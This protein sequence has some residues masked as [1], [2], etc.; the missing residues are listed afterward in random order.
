MK[1]TFCLTMFIILLSLS[2]SPAQDFADKPPL[3]KPGDSWYYR[4]GKLNDVSFFEHLEVIG[5]STFYGQT[6]YKVL[7][8]SY[9]H[10]YEP[11]DP[12]H[13]HFSRDF[14]YLSMEKS[15]G[16]FE[17]PLMTPP[18]LRWPLKN[19]MQWQNPHY[20]PWLD[21]YILSYYSV[22]RERV[23]VPAG[24]FDCFRVERVYNSPDNKRFEFTYWY[25][26]LVGN[27]IKVAHLR[28]FVDELLK[29]SKEK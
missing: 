15:D 12:Y 11:F 27:W 28:G 9:S 2:Q 14:F 13:L 25:S 1:K 21:A 16:K 7:L 20:E 24:V 3:W 17:T 26:P 8:R 29:Y 4:H 23:S 18:K 10:K 22:S 19:Y 6:S 5:F